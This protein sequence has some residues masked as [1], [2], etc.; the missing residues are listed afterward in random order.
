MSAFRQNNHQKIQNI[1][2][3]STTENPNQVLVSYT[4]MSPSGKGVADFI[5]FKHLRYMKMRIKY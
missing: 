5:T 2:N 1:N 3:R 4:K